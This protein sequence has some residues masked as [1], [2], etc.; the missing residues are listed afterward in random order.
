MSDMLE[1]N[2]YIGNVMYSSADEVFHG[3]LLGISDHITYEGNSIQALKQ[4]FT[5]AVEDY[6]QGCRELNKTPETPVQ[7]RFTIRIS[8]ELHKKLLAL[9]ST[10]KQPFNTVVEEALRRYVG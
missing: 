1:Y 8:P 4:D 7:G 3:K 9:S 10:R 6:L 5:E 2:G